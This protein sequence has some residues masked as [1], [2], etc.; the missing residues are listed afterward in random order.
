MGTSAQRPQ[1][2]GAAMGRRQQTFPQQ[3]L[4]EVRRLWQRGARQLHTVA[5][6][7]RAS[8]SASLLATVL[9][10]AAASVFIALVLRV[11]HVANISLVY[12]PIVLWLGARF[13]SWPAILGS[14]LSFLAYDFFFIP[15]V[16]RLTVN[17]PTEWL[18]LA[19]LLATSLVIG[20]MTAAVQARAREAQESRE[21]TVTLYRLAEL[22]VATTT[23]E[24]LLPA[25]VQRVREVF[26]PAG[27]VACGLILTDAQGRPATRALA[28]A[29]DPAATAPLALESPEQRAQATWALE[30]G[31][32]VG[33]TIRRGERNP[34]KL[35]DLEVSYFVPLR[36]RERVVGLLGVA[37]TAA[38]RELVAGTYEA[39][40]VESSGAPAPAPNASAKH[41]QSALFVA[42]CGQIA[43]ALDRAAF[44]QE[45]MHAEA[46]RESD[47]LKD[48]LLGSVTHDLRTPLASIEAAAGSLLEP[49]IAWSEAERRELAETIMASAQRLNRLVTNLLDLSRLEAGVA[50]PEMRWY[51]IGDVIATVLDQLDLIGRTDGY[52]IAVDV[53]DDVPPVPMD[54]AQIEQVLTNLLENALKYSPKGS[55]IMILARARAPNRDLEVRVTDQGI[56]IPPHELDAIFSKFYRVQNVYLPWASGRPPAGTGLGLAISAAI[57]NA[58]GGRIWAESQPGAGATFI[59]TLPIPEQPPESQ[60][61]HADGGEQATRPAD[62][63]PPATGAGAAPAKGTEA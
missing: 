11:V 36:S 8:R 9:S 31:R 40:K 12:L 13:G 44:Q 16:H 5:T 54:H 58:H 14:V 15:P 41:A 43:L 53:P 61:Q 46:L 1:V 39:P 6:T 25:L 24:A 63:T 26:A 18:S 59:F 51:P 29:D 42:F 23:F 32:P 2:R 52:E 4:N 37:G 3:A 27:V 62:E 38:V 20:Q 34:D 48:A 55:T 33:G 7:Q 19:A 22:I 56:G 35:P 60:L 49:D 45:A 47:S 57:I 28:P 50:V 30:R 17:D 10:V 21:R